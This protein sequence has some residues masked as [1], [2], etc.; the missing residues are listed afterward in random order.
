MKTF[1]RPAFTV[2]AIAVLALCAALFLFLDLSRSQHASRR[3]YA[4]AVRGLDLI[5]DL[6]YQAQEAR[7]C[8]KARSAI[9]H[10]SCVRQ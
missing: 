9:S 10:A 2:I 7:R 8:G 6:Q 4:E 3:S 5:G 1:N